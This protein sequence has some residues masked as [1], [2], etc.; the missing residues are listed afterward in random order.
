[1]K[2]I[3]KILTL[4]VSLA[5][6]G[7]GSG[8]SNDSSNTSKPVTPL[9]PSNPIVPDKFI[10]NEQCQEK[11]SHLV[12]NTRYFHC[13]VSKNNVGDYAVSASLHNGLVNCQN[14]LESYFNDNVKVNTQCFIG[15]KGN[16]PLI[17]LEPSF[18]VPVYEQIADLLNEDSILLESICSFDKCSMNNDTP[19]IK[20]GANK[21]YLPLTNQVYVS[22][23][24]VDESNFNIVL[25]GLSMYSQYG[26]GERDYKQLPLNL[27]QVA[28]T[29][30]MSGL[31]NLNHEQVDLAY[32]QKGSFCGTWSDPTPINMY[33]KTQYNNN[34]VTA[35]YSSLKTTIKI[36]DC[37]DKAVFTTDLGQLIYNRSITLQNQ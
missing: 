36:L 8:G 24:S 20:L 26:N 31:F 3:N 4:S 2:K 21:Y 37:K 27:T 25:T 18:P 29:I 11:F 10:D 32:N 13:M 15:T 12:D 34:G 23:N 7:C 1:M 17:P 16:K 14:S 33:M 5:L 22:S 28:D 35:I 6:I 30:N 9:D 19:S